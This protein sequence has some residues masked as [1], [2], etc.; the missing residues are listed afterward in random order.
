MQ[1]RKFIPK[2]ILDGPRKNDNTTKDSERGVATKNQNKDRVIKLSSECR[3]LLLKVKGKEYYR[4]HSRN[5]K[6][7]T[8]ARV[9]YRQGSGHKTSKYRT[10]PNENACRLCRLEAGTLEHIFEI[11][12]VQ[13]QKRKNVIKRNDNGHKKQL[14]VLS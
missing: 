6:K 7:Q 12:N 4:R 10:E 11:R 5:K 14:S 1:K 2:K 8:S 9:K 3:H 13:R